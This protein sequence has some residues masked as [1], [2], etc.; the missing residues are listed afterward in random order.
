MGRRSGLLALGLLAAGVVLLLSCGLIG[1][2]GSYGPSAADRAQQLSEARS[3][4]S[5]RALTHYRMVMQ[6]PSWCRLDIEIRHE[7]IVK[8]FENSC[9]GAPQT[10]TGLFELIKQLDSSPDRLYCAPAGCECTEVRFVQADYDDQ[11]GF[12]RSIRLRRRRALDWSNLWGF[13]MTHGVPNCLSPLDLE[14]V[15]VISF[16]P[17]G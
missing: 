17:M 12:P 15:N 10:V 11:F 13:F 7:Q 6:A 1:L 4:W 3:R 14:V 9:P 8:V 16:K 2:L 5:S